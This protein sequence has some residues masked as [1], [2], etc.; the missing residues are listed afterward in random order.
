MWQ[1]FLLACL[2]PAL[3]VLPGPIDLSHY[4]DQN[5]LYWPGGRHFNFIRVD[6]R[7]S[8]AKDWYAANDFE[9][10]EHGGTHLDAPYHFHS[11]HW[12]VGD[13][14]LERF[15]GKGNY[16]L[17]LPLII[18]KY[19]SIFYKF[20]MQSLNSILKGIYNST[21]LKEN[22]NKKYTKLSLT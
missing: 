15:I 18:H 17:L 8:S 21:I 13:I 10:A 20:K 7:G 14:P 22:R 2:S 5:T 16:I 6:T 3:S 11:N 9:T 4:Y 19:R 12:K 1:L